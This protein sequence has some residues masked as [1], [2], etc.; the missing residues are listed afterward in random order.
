M[1]YLLRC[2]FF[3][4]M[5]S[6]GWFHAVAA[7]PA[8]DWWNAAPVYQTKYYALKSD[9][10]AKDVKAL[11]EHMDATY[12]SYVRLFS[13]FSILAKRPP[14][15]YLFLFAD[16]QD[17]IKVLPVHFGVDGQ[18]MGGG[19]ITHNQETV[20]VTFRGDK[21][22]ESMK[23]TLQHEGFHQVA[24][25][26]FPN[27]PVWANEGLAGL[28]GRGIMV[29]DT[30]AIGEFSQGNKERLLAKIQKKQTKSLE[31]LF[32]MSY[33]QWHA[34]LN[35]GEAG[36]NYVQAW[37]LVHFF[38]FAEHRKYEPNFMNFLMQ[39]NR[40]VEWKTA[41]V[42][43]FGTPD[44]QAMEEKWQAYVQ[45]VPTT[46]DHQT[47]RRLDFL[48]AGMEELHKK[49]IH[50]ASLAELKKHLRDMRFEYT[51]ELYG[52]SQKLSALRDDVFE[53]SCQGSPN[54]PRFVL[55]DSRG[56]ILDDH[57]APKTARPSNL[58]TVGLDNACFHADSSI[59]GRS[60][61]YRF[62]VTPANSTET[63]KNTGKNAV[64]KKK[65]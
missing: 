4:L 33:E 14:K 40:R 62:F 22:I 24:N 49:N 7:A 46:D 15:L 56:R 30:L 57:P 18:H 54:E 45:N 29:G 10:D 17:F 23:G 60:V 1:H 20:I 58:M 51:S 31:Q 12:E 5:V 28:F 39:L 63:P 50:P 34:D 43:A 27:L 47:V 38:I 26:F 9:L 8:Q 59:H 19:C 53:V 52:Q 11:G 41:F 6:C 42:N 37:S 65:P 48:A 64:T 3:G 25:L 21:T 2:A 35:E 36:P 32:T 16:R 55:T 13:N 44:F 61:E